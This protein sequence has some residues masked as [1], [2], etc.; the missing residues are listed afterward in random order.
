MPN[1]DGEGKEN[2]NWDKPLIIAEPD[3]Q[4]CFICIRFEFI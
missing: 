1:Q 4:V 3:V 2:M